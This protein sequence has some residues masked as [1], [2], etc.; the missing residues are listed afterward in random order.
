MKPSSKLFLAALQILLCGHVYAGERTFNQ[1]KIAM[2]PRQ[3]FKLLKR[4]WPEVQSGNYP[5]CRDFE[6]N[7][8]ATCGKSAICDW[9]RDPS[10]KSLSLPEW[11]EVDPKEHLT[12][13]QQM[14]NHALYYTPPESWRPIP[15]DMMQRIEAG[16]THMWHTWIDLDHDGQKE[17][18]VKFNDGPC[19]QETPDFYGQRTNMAVVDEAISKVDTRYLYPIHM[20][21]IVVHEGRAYVMRRGSGGNN[22]YMEEPFS[23][24]GGLEKGA[25]SVCVFQYLK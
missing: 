10:I 11:E 23:A 17:H 24:R 15:P 6:K 8:N 5:V 7:L 18:V 4:K 3:C 25:I 2:S 21:G 14:Q 1:E 19:D 9:K 16:K 20:I 12:V 22:L 13:I